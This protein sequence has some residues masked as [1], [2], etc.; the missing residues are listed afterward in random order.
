MKYIHVEGCIILSDFSVT[1]YQH[2]L[3]EVKRYQLND[4]SASHSSV[5]EWALYTVLQEGHEIQSAKR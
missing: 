1:E 4:I 5:G 3:I 2:Y